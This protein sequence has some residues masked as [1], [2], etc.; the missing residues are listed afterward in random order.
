MSALA[1]DTLIFFGL[2]QWMAAF[3]EMRGLSAV[4]SLYRAGIVLGFAFFVSGVYLALAE[5][6][7]ALLLAAAP[8]LILA[9]AAAL[10][11]GI[12]T[13]WWVDPTRALV[14]PGS[15]ATYTA[16]SVAVPAPGIGPDV[17]VPATFF[18]PK[19]SASCPAV[20][21]I[22]GASDTRLA[23]KWRIIGAFLARGL[24]VLTVDPPGHG[25][26]RS[27]PMTVGHALAA[28]RAA[29]DWL[30]QQEDVAGIGACGISLGGCQAAGLAAADPRVTAVALVCT[31]ARL[32]PV[33][34]AV[35]AREIAG[36]FL[37]RNLGLLREAPVLAL[38]REWRSMRPARLGASL[39]RLVDDFDALSAVRS[40]APDGRPVLIVHGTRDTAVPPR[41]ALA[42]REAAGTGGALL[43]VRQGTHVSLVLHAD[44]M[45]R[46]AEW[47]ARHIRA[48]AGGGS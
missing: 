3:G 29:V 42:L 44:E 40:L 34:R 20:L 30:S 39:T 24:S 15:D 11:G 48:N 7:G 6:I 43:W 10:L 27:T 22:C 31:P 46:M 16:R 33:T 12:A 38:W 1:A 9:V 45:G 35:Y 5:P 47:A 2:I 18:Q 25:D 8:S 28:A 37:P 36:L 23:F 14:N 19:T 13:G 41:N 21:L 32:E 4:G 17:F 26:F